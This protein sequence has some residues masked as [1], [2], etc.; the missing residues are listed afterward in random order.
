MLQVRPRV[1]SGLRSSLTD[2]GTMGQ[3]S[4]PT[5]PWYVY[6]GAADDV[7]PQNLTDIVVDKHCKAGANIL[8]EKNPLNLNHRYECAYGITGAYRW[9]M[10][11]HEGIP[12]VPGCSTVKIS[13][14]SI[15][16]TKD[17]LLIQGLMSNVWAY[18]GYDVGPMSSWHKQNRIL[19]GLPEQD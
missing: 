11:R 14:E 7:S 15:R 6:H 3:H 4:T 10:D 2:V 13:S 19:A 17:G 5:I 16:G 8:Y 18:L 12:I 1:I 9:M